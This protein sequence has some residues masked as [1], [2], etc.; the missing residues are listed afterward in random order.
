VLRA[1][2]AM[3]RRSRR[4]RATAAALM[5]CSVRVL[6]DIGIGREHIRLIAR[7]GD[8]SRA[9]SQ[10]V[11]AGPCASRR[12]M[13]RQQAWL[14]LDAA[15]RGKRRGAPSRLQKAAPRLGRRGRL[16]SRKFS[17]LAAS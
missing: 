14:L 4:R 7:G 5:R 8:P 13:L 17:W 11:P 3:P 2:L 12:S 1:P 10:T 9:A 16:K 6:A 15:G